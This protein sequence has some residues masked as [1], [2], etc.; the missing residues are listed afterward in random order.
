MRTERTE[1]VRPIIDALIA[2]AREGMD[3][4]TWKIGDPA[5][6]LLGPICGALVVHLG[7]ELRLDREPVNEQEVRDKVAAELREAARRHPAATARHGALM[8]AARLAETGR[9]T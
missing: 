1:D 9:S 8:D 3:R 5:E 4:S 7:R 6:D 2:A